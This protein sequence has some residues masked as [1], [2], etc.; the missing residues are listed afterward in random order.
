MVQS[1]DRGTSNYMNYRQLLAGLI[2]GRTLSLS[3]IEVKKLTNLVDSYAFEEFTKQVNTQ[4]VP[5]DA[6][7][8]GSHDQAASTTIRLAYRAAL[9]REISDPE[10]QERLPN[11][12][13]CDFLLRELIDSE[14]YAEQQE[15]NLHNRSKFIRL[16]FEYLLGRDIEDAELADRLNRWQSPADL[17][18][19]LVSSSEYRERIESRQLDLGEHLGDSLHLLGRSKRISAEELLD[20]HKNVINTLLSEPPQKRQLISH[21]D[22]PDRKCDL[23]I[24]SSL[25]K[26]GAHIQQFMESTTSQDDFDRCL[27][28]IIDANSPDHEYEIIKQYEETFPNIRYDRLSERIGIYEAWNH[29]I[30]NSDSRFLT[31]ANIDDLHRQDALRKK[32]EALDEN[33]DVDVAYSDVFYSFLPNVPFEAFSNPG[34]KT[35]LPVANRQNLLQMNS[36]HNAPIWRRSLHDELG[37]FNTR[38]RSAGDYEFWLRVAFAGN[39]F[40]K[41][42]DAVTGYLHNVNGMSTK[43]DSPGVLEG[44]EIIAAFTARLRKESNK[45][46]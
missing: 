4:E 12:K 40:F 44:R 41:I 29:A 9:R 18:T 2:H 24:L 21:A 5:A 15:T 6:K 7:S 46:D 31:S 3:E 13:D 10:M 16:I 34:I 45:P 27:L 22:K 25:Y 19:E 20:W 36:P 26:G 42:A 32:M 17:L 33:D 37:L 11:Y 23:V 39:R 30:K 8:T 38:Y 28:Y 14:E 35:N 1:I 43:F